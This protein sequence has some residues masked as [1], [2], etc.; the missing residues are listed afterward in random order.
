MTPTVIEGR[1]TRAQMVD[2]LAAEIERRTLPR[3]GET[4]ADVIAFARVTAERLVD[5]AIAMS[6]GR[7]VEFTLTSRPGN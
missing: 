1:F 3:E 2:A 5:E 4:H 6:D 7:T